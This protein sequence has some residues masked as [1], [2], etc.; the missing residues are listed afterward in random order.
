[1][2][3][4]VLNLIAVLGTGV[5]IIG[6]NLAV[7]VALYLRLDTKIDSKVEDCYQKLD[8][9]IDSKVGDCYQ[10]IDKLDSKV[11][12]LARD[13]VDIKVAV[14][15]IEGHLDA[16]DGFTPAQSVRSG[17]EPDPEQASQEFRQVG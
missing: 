5:A 12:D 3:P 7:S 2:E 17:S 4:D 13:V 8:K 10:K 6:V 11:D 16:R 9:K 14:A 15:R 1:M